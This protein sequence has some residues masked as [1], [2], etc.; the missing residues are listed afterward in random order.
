MT[1]YRMHGK[2]TLMCISQILSLSLLDSMLPGSMTSSADD[3]NHYSPWSA[4]DPDVVHGTASSLR[5]VLRRS[6][7]NWCHR[8]YTFR[9]RCRRPWY[10][11]GACLGGLG[12]VQKVRKSKFLG[13]NG[14][15]VEVPC[16]WHYSYGYED[17][18]CTKAACFELSLYALWDM[19]YAMDF[20]RISYS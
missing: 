9:N 15:G 12:K 8:I 20:L 19:K 11:Y 13:A 4:A 16:I 3:I 18:V 14:I 10:C 17:V 5:R 2:P 6:R 1:P 7:Y